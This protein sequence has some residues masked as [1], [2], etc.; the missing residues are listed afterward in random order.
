MSASKVAAET[1]A[2][3]TTAGTVAPPGDAG[4]ADG[5][6]DGGGTGSGD[7]G[8]G[9]GDDGGGGGDGSG[10]G[11]DD[12]DDAPDGETGEGC[13]GGE[14]GCGVHGWGS[15]GKGTVIVWLMAGAAIVA[16]SPPG[17]CTW[18][19]AT[20]VDRLRPKWAIGSWM[21]KQTQRNRQL[22]RPLAGRPRP[23]G[24]V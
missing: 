24:G 9:G 23:L 13:A 2:V 8:D 7:D 22:G 1:V 12:G 6:G 20:L 14:G 3:K 18:T 15:L 5:V 4:G 19:E 17:H 11:R 21:V 16:H 10:G